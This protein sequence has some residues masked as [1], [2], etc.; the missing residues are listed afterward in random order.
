MFVG[1][2]RDPVAGIPV[3]M[4]VGANSKTRWLVKS[5]NISFLCMEN[6]PSSAAF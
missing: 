5:R 2:V 4:V 6:Q 1:S 3:V